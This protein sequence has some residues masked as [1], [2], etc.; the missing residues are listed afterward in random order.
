MTYRKPR[1]ERVMLV[2]ALE[3]K[4]SIIVTDGAQT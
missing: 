1:V 4:V 2:G 3:P